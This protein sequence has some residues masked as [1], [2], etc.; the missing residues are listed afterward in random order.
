M[1]EGVAAGLCALHPFPLIG[2]IA[3]PYA[4]ENSHGLPRARSQKSIVGQIGAQFFGALGSKINFSCL[5][6]CQ[7]CR[8]QKLLLELGPSS[9]GFS[10]P[11][12]QQVQTEPLAIEQWTQS[13]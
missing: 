6:H 1:S 8:K 10:A 4:S 12:S 7:R 11:R 13:R 2:L 9:M 3:F 5:A